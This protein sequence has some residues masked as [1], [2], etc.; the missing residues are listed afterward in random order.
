LGSGLGSFPYVYTDLAKNFN[1][2][3]SSHEVL[4][5]SGYSTIYAQTYFANLCNDVGVFSLILLFVVFVGNSKINSQN[6]RRKRYFS[7]FV[8]L[9]FQSQITSPAFW[10]ILF[11]AKNDRKII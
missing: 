2:D 7:L 1:L 6:V 11:L 3:L 8:L 10:I 9:F 4:G 5:N